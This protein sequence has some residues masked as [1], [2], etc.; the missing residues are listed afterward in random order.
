M[1]NTHGIVI[2]DAPDYA[3]AGVNLLQQVYLQ[4]EGIRAPGRL[5]SFDVP[6]RYLAVQHL[7]IRGHAGDGGANIE[8][9]SR[10]VVLDTYLQ[11]DLKNEEPTGPKAGRRRTKPVLNG[12]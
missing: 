1:V 3:L 4:P 7:Y 11:P 2:L 10:A 12:Y 6:H 8:R 9:V 5:S